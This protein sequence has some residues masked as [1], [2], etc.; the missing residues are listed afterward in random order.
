M[1]L[2]GNGQS[3]IRMG[4]K[5]AKE[6]IKTIRKLEN[7]HYGIKMDRKNLKL[8]LLRVKLKGHALN[9][10]KMGGKKRKEL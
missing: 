10:M 2:T 3:G 4:E 7:I 9:G 5:A 8:N 6:I 1:N